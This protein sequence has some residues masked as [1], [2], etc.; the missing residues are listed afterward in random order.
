MLF[1]LVELLLKIVSWTD[2]FWQLSRLLSTTNSPTT[3]YSWQTACCRFTTF[4]YLVKT[5]SM[6]IKLLL[7]SV[8]WLLRT[9]S[10]NE[11]WPFTCLHFDELSNKFNNANI[12]CQY[13]FLSLIKH[14]RRL[15]ILLIKLYVS[16]MYTF[17]YLTS[18]L[19]NLKKKRHIK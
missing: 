16:Q 1:R 7:T 4:R 14:V 13:F 2:Q 10:A 19:F 3:F 6:H 9:F 17:I 8:S 15:W 5:F 18:D 12:F 11:I